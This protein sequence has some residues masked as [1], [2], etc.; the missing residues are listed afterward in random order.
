MMSGSLA[1]VT[2]MM[3]SAKTV[4][5]TLKAKRKLVPFGIVGH[6]VTYLRAD[7]LSKS[8]VVAVLQSICIDGFSTDETTEH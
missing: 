1:A 2:R 8:D 4:L 7:G 3:S 6:P 5:R